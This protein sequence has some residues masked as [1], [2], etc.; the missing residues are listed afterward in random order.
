MSHFPI[1]LKQLVT[2]PTCHFTDAQVTIL[3]DHLGDLDPTIRDQTVYTLLARG[4]E[5]QAFSPTQRQQISQFLITRR[6]L[7]TGI[8][9]PPSNAVFC[10]T[11][12][13]L[14]TALVLTDDAQ[15]PWLTAP[16]RNQ[17][18]TD[19]LTYLP[20]ERDTRGWVPTFGWAHG[21]AHGSDLLG[22]A[23]SHPQFSIDLTPT[24]LAA[25]QV[26]LQRQITIFSND[27]EPRLANTLVRAMAAHHLSATDLITWLNATD[28]LLWTNFSFDD[29]PATARLHNWLSVL[30]HLYLLLPA[31]TAVHKTLKT[32]SRH[33]YHVNGYV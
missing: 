18:F 25:L 15:T 26:V 31:E 5:E 24:A 16:N 6:T 17:L 2:A 11:F 29:R 30:H 9:Q 13:A 27:E 33:Y 4:F 10:R 21:I 19:A 20:T 23:W 1:S 32:L 12:T 8:H 28:Q 3:L 7:F 22:A 14:L